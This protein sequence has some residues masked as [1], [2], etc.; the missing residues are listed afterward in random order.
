MFKFQVIVFFPSEFHGRPQSEGHV[1]GKFKTLEA[2][3]KRV[4]QL[5]KEK[6][7]NWYMACEI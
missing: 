1:I 7:R 5:T 3:K 4:L 6:P 2:A